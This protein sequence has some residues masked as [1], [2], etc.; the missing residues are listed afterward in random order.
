MGLTMSEDFARFKKDLAALSD[1]DPL[2]LNKSIGEGLVSSTKKRFETGK[3]PDGTSWP[4]SYR[5]KEKGGKTLAE[6]AHLKNS[7]NPHATATS[8][9][10]GTNLKYAHVHQN[11]MVIKPK[12][13]KFLHFQS[14]GLWAN[15]KQVTI[16]KRPFLG[17]S[18]ED[19]EEI[20]STV[21]KHIKGLLP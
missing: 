2:A 10:V 17:I 16:P 7:I 5:V 19:V 20:D 14:G 3:A 13:A 9:E 1:F 15:K 12:T 4:E 21:L 6:N 18:D 8:V 11:G